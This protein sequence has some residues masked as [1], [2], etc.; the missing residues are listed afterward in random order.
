M[1][2]QKTFAPYVQNAAG[3]SPASAQEDPS[4]GFVPG[5]PAGFPASGR[6]KH[7]HARPPSTARHEQIMVTYGHTVVPVHTD[8]LAGCTAGQRP[9]STAR[10]APASSVPAVPPP[11]GA[12]AEP[13]DPP[14]PPVPPVVPADPA[15]PPVVPPTPP[16]PPVVLVLVVPVVVPPLPDLPPVVVPVVPVVVVVSL[17]SPP[18][19]AAPIATIAVDGN[20][21]HRMFMCSSTSQHSLRYALDV[22]EHTLVHPVVDCDTWCSRFCLAAWRAWSA[23]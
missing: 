20:T 7:S 11:S 22:S 12:P 6:P 23:P 1:Q 18:H 14:V 17:S 19:C 2:W 8:P 10:S 3:D 16:E 9:A 21:H 5:H 15:L 13:A 4:A